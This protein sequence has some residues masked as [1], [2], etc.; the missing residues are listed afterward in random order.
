MDVHL[1]LPSFQQGVLIATSGW[2]LYGFLRVI[3]NVFFHPLSRFPGPA[4]AACTRWWLAYMQL[5]RGVDLYTK[6]AEYHQ[7]YGDIIRIAPNELHFARPTAYHEIYNAQNKWDKDYEFYRA[8]DTDKSFFSQTEYLKSKHGRAL[9]SNL[10]SKQ[11]IS[12]L[13]HLVRGR[14]D[15]FCDALKEQHAAGKSSNLYRG[16][17]CFSADTITNFLFGTSFDQLSFPDFRGNIVEGIDASIPT[18]TLM[19]F[20]PVVIWILRNFPPPILVLVS[21]DSFK[22]LILFKNALKTQIKNILRNPRSLDDAPHRTIYSE[23]L[24][25]EVNKGHNIPTESQ[26]LHEAQVLFA[27]GSHTAGTTLMTGVCH[28]LRSPE[29]KQR[30]V[31]EVRAAWPVL[32]QPP[33]YEVLEKLPFLASA[34]ACLSLEPF[35]HERTEQTAVIK[36]TLRMAGTV[37]IGLPRVV[38]RS[39]AV[40]SGVKIP[41]GVRVFIYAYLSVAVT[42]DA[43]RDQTVVSQSSFFVLY[44][45]EIFAQPHAFVPDRWLQPGSKSLENWFVA[46]SKGPRSCLGIN[47]A[48]CELYLALAHL[49]RRFDVTED[50]SRPADLRFTEHALPL[51]KGQHLRVYCKPQSD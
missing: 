50:L 30:L 2:L 13:Q 1:L 35:P 28:L 11:A 34:F 33:T 36:E 16:F 31:D 27:A 20:S 48:Y 18:V 5:G 17:Q 39:G 6:R 47:L 44:S 19:K 9:I 49:F 32:D 41:G 37:P 51:F 43:L 46:F 40:I 14:L 24:N 12:G 3:Y 7:K 21:P 42:S 45:E 4:G 26:L 22:G 38:P 10:F 15:C 25:P 29:A 8:F 23:F